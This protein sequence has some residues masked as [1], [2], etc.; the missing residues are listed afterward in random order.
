MVNG[1]EG[2]VERGRRKRGRRKKEEQEEDK[3]QSITEGQSAERWRHLAKSRPQ[4][5]HSICI[6]PSRGLQS[7]LQKWKNQTTPDQRLVP[8][9]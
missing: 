5:S 4:I 8:E 2:K 9:L 3:D 7:F 6:P 1:M